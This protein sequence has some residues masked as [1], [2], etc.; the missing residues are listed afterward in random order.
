MQ[1]QATGKLIAALVH[2]ATGRRGVLQGGG[3]W[4]GGDEGHG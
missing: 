2:P 1:E 4:G 3:G